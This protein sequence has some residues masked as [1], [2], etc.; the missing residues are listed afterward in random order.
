MLEL[1]L[2]PIDKPNQMAA[3]KHGVMMEKILF[4]FIV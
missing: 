1:W 3:I 2:K 4:Y